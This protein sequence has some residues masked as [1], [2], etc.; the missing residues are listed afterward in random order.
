[1]NQSTD[2]NM[3]QSILDFWFKEITPAQMWKVD[4]AFDRLIADR[5]GDIHEQAT[6]AE[7]FAWR[8]TPHGRLA[9]IIVSTSSPATSTVAH[10]ARLK[11]TLWL[12]HSRKKLFQR[13][14]MKH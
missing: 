13:R 11:P 9:E 12:W 8:A 10:A 2:S 4:P 5:F 6:R 7:L 14:Q 3:H 1:M